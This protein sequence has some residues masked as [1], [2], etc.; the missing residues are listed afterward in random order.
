MCCL[1][2]GIIEETSNC[3]LQS[4]EIEKKLEDNLF[5]LDITFSWDVK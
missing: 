1:V 4:F 2:E 5:F 3:C